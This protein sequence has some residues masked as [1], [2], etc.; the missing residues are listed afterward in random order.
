[1]CVC[2]FMYHSMTVI[3]F[4]VLCFWLTY[5]WCGARPEICGYLNVQIWVTGCTKIGTYRPNV[6]YTRVSTKPDDVPYPIE[7]TRSVLGRH[8]I[9]FQIR[10]R[11][12]DVKV[13]WWR[14]RRR[15]PWMVVFCTCRWPSSTNVH[16]TGELLWPYRV[17]RFFT[18][19]VGTPPKFP[20]P[21]RKITL[22]TQTFRD[23]EFHL[24]TRS[25]SNSHLSALGRCT[26]KNDIIRCNSWP[27][28][29]TWPLDNPTYH[30][31]ETYMG[32]RDQARTM[33]VRHQLKL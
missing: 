4:T 6:D 10:P 8:T 14:P 17:N 2:W 25:V 22:H 23:S 3:F 27:N 33:H 30:S 16:E 31:R 9:G 29:T 5:F 28:M 11:E 24:H 13:T 32:S 26:C 7:P 1:M 18:P 19:A 12:P 20:N 21:N 15:R